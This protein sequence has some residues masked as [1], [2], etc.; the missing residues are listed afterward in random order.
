M[1]RGVFNEQL[2]RAWRHKTGQCFI[3]YVDLHFEPFLEPYL[4]Q[5]DVQPDEDHLVSERHDFFVFAL[6]H[7]SVYAGK[8]VGV[9]A[10]LIGLFLADEAVQDV[11]GVEQEM[12]VD[13]SFQLEISVLGHIGLLPFR[14]H[15]ISC[16]DRVVD[17]V[18]D[19]IHG[20]L[21]DHRYD[22]EEDEALSLD[23][24]KE[25]LKKGCQYHESCV[26]EHR[27]ELRDIFR[28]ACKGPDEHY[29]H[30][31]QDNQSE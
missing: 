3:R 4:K 11:E 18:Y 24:D 20:Y 5:V 12:R 17:H 19:A 7:I 8:L 23:A 26:Q 16:G 30:A 28:P 2:D 13:L 21:G 22:E 14:M 25:S 15:L 1:L 6:D 31:D 10:C 9:C 29:V 27:A